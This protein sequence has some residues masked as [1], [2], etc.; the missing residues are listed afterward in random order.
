MTA[1]LARLD[2]DAGSLYW[3]NAGHPAGLVLT[4]GTHQA[5]PSTGPPA[6]L[7]PDAHYDAHVLRLAAGDS[8][9]LVTD[10]VTEAIEAGGRVEERL[11]WTVAQRRS[12]GPQAVCDRLMRLAASGRG[13]VGAG[14]WQDDRTVVAVTLDAT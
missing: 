8:L 14:N 1:F 4:G 5:L 12:R 9:V 11:A 7:L 10:G 3:V 13:P 6:G 2:L